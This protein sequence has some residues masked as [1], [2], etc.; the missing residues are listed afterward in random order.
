MKQKVIKAGLILLSFLIP[1]GWVFSQ[2]LVSTSVEVGDTKLIITGQAFPGA[3]I[4]IT[5][6]GIAIGTVT[7]G[8]EGNF[9][10]TLF[11][12]EDGNRLIGLTGID[13]LGRS[14][15]LAVYSLNL[16]RGIDNLLS[17]IILPPTVSLSANEITQ[18]E[19]VN[20]E[21]YGPPGAEI[22]VF[23]GKTEIGR[24][25]ADSL[26]HYLYQYEHVSLSVGNY[27]FS[28][29]AWLGDRESQ[30]S[31]RVVLT[32]KAL[33]LP[34]PTTAM[35]TPALT[36]VFISETPTPELTPTLTPTLR[37]LP[38]FLKPFDINHDGRLNRGEFW[39]AVEIW[40][41]SWQTFGAELKEKGLKTMAV[42]HDCDLN[43]D[44]FCDLIDFS[45]LL[46]N[47]GR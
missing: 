37:L 11:A 25:T 47:I 26:G 14:T 1:T 3:F 41:K 46:Y 20:F 28:L 4:T 39:P 12:Q 24:T 15:S 8:P 22:L 29:K 2:E 27:D 19:S 5:E 42:K 10:K 33:P 38:E 17:E 45:I 32:V 18:G 13:L 23:E 34:T 40:V 35:V 16:V 43:R 6:N 31:Q 9:Q 21:G 30:A 36:P 44:N 7:A